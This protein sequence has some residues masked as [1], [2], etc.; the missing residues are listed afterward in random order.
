MN[1]LKS[2]VNKARQSRNEDLELRHIEY[3]EMKYWNHLTADT[4]W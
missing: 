3:R 2:L 1:N 4:S